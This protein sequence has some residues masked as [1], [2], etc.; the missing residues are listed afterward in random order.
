MLTN[1]NNDFNK[2]LKSD[3]INAIITF[4]YLEFLYSAV[5]LK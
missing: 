2:L 5:L 3:R 4:H 1:I